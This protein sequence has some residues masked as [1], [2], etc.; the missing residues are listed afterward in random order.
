MLKDTLIYCIYVYVFRDS[1]VKSMFKYTRAL[2]HTLERAK[3][4]VRGGSERERENGKKH[5]SVPCNFEADIS[6]SAKY[7]CV[8]GVPKKYL[9]SIRQAFA[10]VFLENPGYW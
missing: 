7:T 4:N 1:G 10:S 3:V 9:F 5:V 6:G 2:K 8:Y